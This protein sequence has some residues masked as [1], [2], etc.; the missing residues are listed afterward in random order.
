MGIVLIDERGPVRPIM[1]PNLLLLVKSFHS[2]VG[3]A[4]CFQDYSDDL[5]WF[6]KYLTLQLAEYNLSV[7]TDLKRPCPWPSISE[8]PITFLLEEL[9]NLSVQF[10][11]ACLWVCEFRMPDLAPSTIFDSDDIHH[12]DLKQ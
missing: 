2:Q 11:I 12:I 9:L 8:H 3:L 4:L 6:R 5:A 1:V 7:E 10:L